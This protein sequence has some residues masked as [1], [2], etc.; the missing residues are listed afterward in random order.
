MRYVRRQLADR[1]IQNPVIYDVGANVGDYAAALNGAFPAASIYCFEPSAASSGEL[2][3]RMAG[4]SNV[5]VHDFGF[6][7]KEGVFTLFLDSPVSKTASMYDLPPDH[8]WK[9]N[10]TE[11]IRLKTI[12]GFCVEA[13]VDRINFLKI[14]A[15]GH[16]LS[17]LKG[18][19]NMLAAGKVDYIQF[20]FGCRQIDSRTYFRDFFQFLN[21]RYILYR[22]LKDGLLRI[23]TYHERLEIFVLVSN[24]LAELRA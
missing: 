5:A 1:K 9:S 17:V 12:D 4:L 22:I 19:V 3:K 2:R 10:M 20:E 15:E 16:E 7:E 21:S 23:D 14:D 11:S 8:V 6:G 24:F 18:A 13:D